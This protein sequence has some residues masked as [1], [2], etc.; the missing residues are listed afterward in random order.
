MPGHDGLDLDGAGRDDDLLGRDVEHPVRHPR[1]DRWARV[2]PDD[3]VPVA[4]VEDGRRPTGRSGFGRGLAPGFPAA[5]DDDVD[6]LGAV[7]TMSVSG[8]AVRRQDRLALRRVP[9]DVEPGPSRDLAAPDVR[10]AVD[11]DE[12]VAAVA[13]E[14]ERPAGARPAAGSDDRDATES[15]ASNARVAVDD[16]PDARACLASVTGASGDPAGRTAAPAGGA[17]AGA[18][19]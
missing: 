17:P 1:H 15:P 11:L 16:D 12:A 4:G 14:A 19:R 8:P 2:D 10:D 7:T 18:G 13:G 3:L 5:D 9:P 6:L